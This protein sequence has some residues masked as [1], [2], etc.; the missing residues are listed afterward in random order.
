MVTYNIINTDNDLLIGKWF[1]GKYELVPYELKALQLSS[2]N[3][4]IIL[5]LGT[6]NVVR[7]CRDERFREI[8]IPHVY[9]LGHNS[10]LTKNGY[11]YY[12]D[13]TYKPILLDKDVVNVC[14]ITNDGESGC[15]VK[16]FDVWF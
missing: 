6:D 12:F 13:K 8:K 15:Y 10:F 1:T 4:K 16:R 5:I 2:I 3:K 7:I 9:M 11:L 14:Y